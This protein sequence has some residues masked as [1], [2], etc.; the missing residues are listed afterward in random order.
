MKHHGSR[1]L[2]RNAQSIK[3]QERF[4]MKKFTLT[5]ALMTLCLNLAHGQVIPTNEWVNFWSD[6]SKIN[7]NFLPVGSVV[8]A[9]SPK[10]VLCGQFTVKTSGAYGMMPVYRADSTSNP[11]IPGAQPGDTIHFTINNIPAVPLGPKVP[12]WTTNGD[13]E[14]VNL[15]V[16]KPEIQIGSDSL[17]FGTVALKS[18]N[19]LSLTIKNT[20]LKSLSVD[21]IKIVYHFPQ[22]FSLS[23]TSTTLNAGASIS[24]SITFSPLLGSGKINAAAKIYS[25]AWNDSIA[26]IPVTATI[27]TDVVPT[28]EWVSFW[29]DSVTLDGKSVVP[30]DVIDA[31]DSSGVHCGTFTVTSSGQYGLMPVYRDDPTTK[32]IDE[33]ASPG[34][35]IVF[36]VNGYRAIPKGPDRTIWTANGAVFKVNLQGTT[37]LPPVLSSPSTGSTGVSVN[38]TLTWNT[39]IGALS[40]RMQVSTDS[41]FVST[42][43]DTSG[44]A[45]TSVG[46]KGLVNL[47]KYYWRVEAGN[48]GG[49]SD[50]SSVW[51]FTTVIAAPAAPGLASPGHNAANQ[52]SKL[53]LK[54][55]PAANATGYHWQ[56]SVSSVFSSAVV[57][58]STAGVGDTAHSVV[59][60]PGTKYYWR[61]Q[62]YNAG[63]ASA[64]SNPDSFTTII[65][66]P[67]KPTLISPKRTTGEPRRTTFKWNSSAN[68]SK[69]HLQVAIDTAFSNLRVD[70]TTS[71]TVIKIPDTLSSQATYYWHVSAIDTAG[72]SQFSAFAQ[73]TTGTGV[74][75]VNE[76]VGGPKE[77]GLSQNYPN[78]FNPSTTISYQLPAVSHVALKVYDALGRE[79]ATLVNEV[80]WAGSY[81]VKF[82]ASNLPSGVYFY[83][84]T[85]G[86]FVATKKLLLVK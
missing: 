31:Y 63:G 32:S 71:D 16:Q 78:P 38:P 84:L 81:E 20:G 51:N 53:T 36:M 5:M 47:T 57:N 54:V 42:K 66:V 10:G 45:I 41:T 37:L 65:A 25:N 19:S 2:K 29:G 30:G 73:F 43:F 70:L 85:A 80:K 67:A 59:L 3:K 52:P 11:V 75:G 55:N 48:A 56:V 1:P 74:L 9:Y 46:L 77:F 15:V 4:D 23:T 50:W 17:S 13:V 44:V 83:R 12:I 6:S 64:F 60:A 40:Y 21:S 35:S 69:Y 8:R 58:D 68:A 34:D 82:D 7:N 24:L 72:E 86:N 61:V 27:K 28:N 39:S 18:S 49:T 14:K 62:A 26:S 76:N 79:V 22:H 33:G